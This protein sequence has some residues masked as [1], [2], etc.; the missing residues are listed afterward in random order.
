[1]FNRIL[2][3]IIHSAECRSEFCRCEYILSLIGN[4][5]DQNAGKKVFVVIIYDLNMAISYYII[6]YVFVYDIATILF[7]LHI[8]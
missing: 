3:T 2:Y 8:D 7:A 5:S 6:F 1:M 4:N